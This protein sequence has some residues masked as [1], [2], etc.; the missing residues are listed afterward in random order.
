MKPYHPPLLP[1][2]IY[3]LNTI[4]NGTPEVL[5]FAP[6]GQWKQNKHRKIKQIVGDGTSGKVNGTTL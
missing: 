6:Q 2:G 1:C 3:H 4:A 5:C